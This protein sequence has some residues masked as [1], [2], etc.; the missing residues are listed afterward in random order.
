MSRV[1]LAIVKN[2]RCPC[3]SG[4]IL[5]DCCGRYLAGLGEGKLAPTA[6]ALMR[7]RFTAFALGD[8]EHLL[9][10][11]HPTT[12]PADLDLDSDTRWL[13]LEILET[14]DGSP[15][16]QTGIVA[17]TATYR[18]AAGRGELRER[19]SF[20]RVDGAWLYVDGVVG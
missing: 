2:G 11:W 9:A 20:E 16:H 10:T 6:E 17:F 8:E 13:H 19:S 14:V 18:D 1:D 5:S 12:R 15:F 3:G 4:E 7:S